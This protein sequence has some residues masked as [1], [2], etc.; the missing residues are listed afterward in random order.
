MLVGGDAGR[1]DLRDAG[2]GDDREAVVDRAGRGRVLQIV[3]LAQRQHEREDALPVVEQDV[4]GLAALHAAEGQR[5]AGGEAQR[6][7]RRDGVEAERHDVRVVAHLHPFF[8]E[9][10][11]HGA[12]VDVAAEEDQ[13]VALLQLAH[14]L[15]R[16]LV[17]LGAADDGREAG[18]AAVHEL[19]APGAELDVVNRAVE[20]ARAV[21]VAAAHI[22]AGEA[23]AAGLVTGDRARLL[24]VDEADGLDDLGG[25]QRR[26]AGVERL[27]QVGRPAVG[28]RDRMQQLFGVLQHRRQLAELGDLAAGHAQDRRQVVSRIRKSHRRLRPALVER[29]VQ[30]RLGFLRD[31]VRAADGARGDVSRHVC[32]SVLCGTRN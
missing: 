20:A 11:D 13:D 12:A 16:D 17:A 5:R 14:D 4:F 22:R 18:H 2:V 25:Q 26:H 19:D 3:H 6:V 10:M 8:H 28:R 30:Q 32:S 7:D 1:Q 27:A 23:A 21:A 9:L 15:D 29:L 31:Q 24:A